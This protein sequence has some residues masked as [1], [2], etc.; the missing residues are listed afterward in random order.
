MLTAAVFGFPQMG[1]GQTKLL[2]SPLLLLPPPTIVLIKLRLTFL[3]TKKQKNDLLLQIATV[4][5]L[6]PA[7]DLLARTLTDPGW[8]Y[9]SLSCV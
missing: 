6:L 1:E 4:I 9:T 7:D 5:A 3:W 8:M 2:L